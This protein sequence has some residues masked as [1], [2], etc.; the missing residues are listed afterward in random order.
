[1]QQRW[2]QQDGGKEEKLTIPH[3]TPAPC[4]VW[5]PSDCSAYAKISY[6]ARRWFSGAG[7]AAW[8]RV[9]SRR[10]DGM[11]AGKLFISIYMHVDFSQA[12]RAGLDRAGYKTIL[13]HC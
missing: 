2:F 11:T 12:G 4:S 10:A 6:S 9:C 8:G 1:M 5:L 13:S 7:L 3:A